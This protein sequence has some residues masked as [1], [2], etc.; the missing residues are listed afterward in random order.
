MPR[1]RFNH[2][3]SFRHVQGE[4]LPC[5]RMYS[6]HDMQN[7][8]RIQV[9]DEP[10]VAL[11]VL[12]VGP[13]IPLGAI[14]F[15]HG[16]AG[17]SNQWQRMV[18]HFSA[19]WRCVAPDLRGHGLSDAPESTYLLDELMADLD[20]LVDR[21]QMPP[22]F[23]VAAHSFGGALGMTYAARRPNR[24][25]KLVLVSTASLV[26]LSGFLRIVLKL[27]PWMLDLIKRFAPGRLSCKGHV[28]RKFIPRAVFP[29][30][31]ENLLRRIEAPTLVIIGEGDRVIPRRAAQLMAEQIQHSQL[32]VIRY[33]KHMPILERPDAVNRAMERFI[34]GRVSSWRGTVEEVADPG[35]WTRL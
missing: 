35:T 5:R 16:A 3:C 24:V 20:A 13:Q 18:A 4:G 12:D 6:W 28:L 2:A 32:E 15:L 29:F 30:N 23:V 25:D 10:V 8:R 1:V 14:L 31:G 27:P 33:A 22:R 34:E 9:S 17:R 26:P 21:L 7:R 19:R 11:S